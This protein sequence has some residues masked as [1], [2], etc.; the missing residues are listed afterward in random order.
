MHPVTA[1]GRNN[2]QLEEEEEPTVEPNSENIQILQ[3]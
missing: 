2:D 3:F 1:T